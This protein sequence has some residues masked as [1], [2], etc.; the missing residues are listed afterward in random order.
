MSHRRAC[1]L[2]VEDEDVR[3]W[4]SPRR[5]A[6]KVGRA[7]GRET[8]VF[9]HGTGLGIQRFVLVSESEEIS[10][11]QDREIMSQAADFFEAAAL[12]SVQDAKSVSVTRRN[13]D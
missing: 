8:A 13:V 3:L 11:G 9:V 10:C 12:K 6:G 5:C 2:L 1:V 7:K 4:G